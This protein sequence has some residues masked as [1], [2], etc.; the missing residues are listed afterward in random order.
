MEI[1][2]KN[3]NFEIFLITRFGIGQ[4]S[5][6]FFDNEFPYLE[7]LLTK[8]VLIQ[9]KYLK[10]WLIIVDVNTPN[11]VIEKLRKLIPADLL[12]I[13]AHDWFSLGNTMPDLIP[14]FKKF[15]IKK[16]DKVITIRVDADDM[17]SNNYVESVIEAVKKN[18]L[19]D[20][21]KDIS[22]NATK[23]IYFYPIRKK[24]VGVSKKNYSVQ[25]LYSTFGENFNSVYDF[26]HQDIGEKIVSKGGYSCE[27]DEDFIW[28]RSIR[29]FSITKFGNQFGVFEARFYLFKNIIK[30]IF[31][32]NSKN[33]T[34]YGE[35]IDTK[36][37][38]NSF[39]IPND[40]IPFFEKFEK[41]LNKHSLLLSA[42]LKRILNTKNI[43]G[44]R[45]KNI[46]INMYKQE[47]NEEVK[48]EIKRDFYKI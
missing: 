27:L 8:S 44:P 18:N 28:I 16:N 14:I 30:K 22:V 38:Y 29:Q 35:V 1:I 11:Y 31:Y 41:K 10:K 6:F 3:V 34:F 4:N 45:A 7:K 47:T 12:Y 36:A 33:N 23:G 48:A 24:L 2:M 5:N 32:K 21:Y 15:G 40:I 26:S 9:R 17:I 42:R 19:D 39:E 37:L 46:L 13:Y 43:N 25:A 20:R